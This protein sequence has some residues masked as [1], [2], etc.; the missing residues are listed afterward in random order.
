MRR[1]FGIPEI[2]DHRFPILLLANMV[3]K[4]KIEELVKEKLDEK[5]FLVDVQ[6]S[7]SNVIKVFVDSFD[8]LTIDQCVK[9]NRHLENSLDRETEDFE[10]QVSSPG[11][12]ESFRVKEQYLKN[13]GREVE[14]V[15]TDG[16]KRS[17]LLKE[18][19]PEFVLLETS[20]REKVEGHKKKQ[21]VVR[22]HQIEYSD[23]KSAKVVVSF[24]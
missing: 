12:T 24:K 5:A 13:A 16:T 22:E 3:N 15:T 8:G 18:V 21:L 23:I 19:K 7:A 2:G 10:L 17:G 1:F 9:I 20:A 14:I 6:V 4:A 11:L